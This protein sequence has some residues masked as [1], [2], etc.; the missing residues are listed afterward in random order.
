MK[1]LIAILMCAGLSG[2]VAATLQAGPAAP[3]IE[4]QAAVSGYR[5]W[6]RVNPKPHRVVSRLAMLCIGLTTEQKAQL[7]SDPHSDKFVT[8]YVNR[9]ARQAMLYQKK[10]VFPQ[11]SLIVKEKLSSPGSKFPELLTVMHKREKGYNPGAGD[12]EYL[13]LN[14]AGTKTQARGKLANCQSCHAEW[15]ETD[16]VSRVYFTDV[17]RRRFS[18]SAPEQSLPESRA[19]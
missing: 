18:K 7:A 19:N 16:Y 12:W 6:V 9:I 15:K 13:V 4:K 11:G 8:V 3:R 1:T 14:G 10:P 17:M 2:V 5:K